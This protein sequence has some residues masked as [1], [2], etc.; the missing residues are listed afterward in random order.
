[1]DQC[2]SLFLAED[3]HAGGEC[4]RIHAARG[5]NGDTDESLA[6]LAARR[7]E[8]VVKPLAIAYKES[9]VIS[10]RGHGDVRDRQADGDAGFVTGM[11]NAHLPVSPAP[12]T[13]HIAVTTE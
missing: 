7:V 11:T 5:E 6:G 13:E 8:D 1:V 2:Q 3:K 9:F 12:V 4:I 10:R